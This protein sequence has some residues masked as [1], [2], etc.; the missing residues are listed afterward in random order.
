MA[1]GVEPDALVY[2]LRDA[3]CRAAIGGGK[4]F[5]GTEGAAPEAKGA[6][7]VG[8]GEAAVHCDFL[9][10]AAEAFAAIVGIGEVGGA[11]GV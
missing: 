11:H 10:C 5:A 9:H 6:V 8:A 2:L 1:L 4:G 7:A 3:A